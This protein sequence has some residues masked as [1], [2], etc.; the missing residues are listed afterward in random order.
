MKTVA[1]LTVGH[2]TSPVAPLAEM[3]VLDWARIDQEDRKNW[4]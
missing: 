4:L 1:M 2:R 3:Y